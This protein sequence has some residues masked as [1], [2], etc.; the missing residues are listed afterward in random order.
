MD[1]LLKW[2]NE[3]KDKLHPFVLAVIF[4]HK[5]EKVH[6]FSDGNGRTGRMLMNYI[7]TRNKYPP[8]VIYKKNRNDYLDA[9]SGADK[10]NLTTIDK[11]YNNL[12]GYVASEASSS[13]WNLFL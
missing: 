12:V 8:I 6:P 13:Y 7:L 3:N 5:F 4:H 2:Y 10:I 9:L 11:K 1:L